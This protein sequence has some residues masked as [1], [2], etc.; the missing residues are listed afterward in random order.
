MSRKICQLVAGYREGDAISN[1]AKLIR[2]VF[3]SWGSDGGIYCNKFSC[4]VESRGEVNDLDKL[5]GDVA[6][7]D[8]AILHLS[9]GCE[10]NA[11]FT[12]LNC[13]KAII[14][15]NIT[16]SRYFSFV[17]GSTAAV[18]D[19]GRRQLQ[20]LAGVADVNAADSAYNAAELTAAGYKD[21]KVLPLPIDLS[22]FTPGDYLKRNIDYDP[23]DGHYNV[24]FV[25]RFAPNKKIENLAKVLFFLSKIEPLV[26]LICIGSTTGMEVYDGLVEAQCR[27]LGLTNFYPK[28]S[29]SQ[30]YLK[31]AY[32]TAHA[33]LCMSEHEGF[34][35]PLVEAMLH[36]VPVF[37]LGTSAVPETMG[38]AGVVF[39]PPPDYPLIAET[40]AEI[41]HN[42]KLRDA[43]V[44]RQDK[45]I[46]EIR[47]RDLSGE[48]KAL[49]AP[50]LSA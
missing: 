31:A 37:A 13:R 8:I 49:L 29:V 33:F 6:P 18:L 9:I 34:C 46:E 2:T 17:N 16:P 44:A 24:I 35:A 30:D 7:D 11:V 22:A 3:R 5:P 48:L 27:I 4:S 1:T 12:R 47:N 10:A 43:I 15:H 20:E 32:S 26:R 45:R 38:G 19:E 41:L 21:V 23:D 50:L 40:I 25:G 39:E 36:H 28:G 14:Y 42:G